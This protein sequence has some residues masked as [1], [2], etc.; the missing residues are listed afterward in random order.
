MDIMGKENFVRSGEGSVTF[1]IIVPSVGQP[2][3]GGGSTWDPP[4]KYFWSPTFEP[5]FKVKKLNPNAM[6]PTKA[7]YGAY[8]SVLW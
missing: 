3:A 7:Y 1:P 2:Y 8:E 6:V 5:L 4:I